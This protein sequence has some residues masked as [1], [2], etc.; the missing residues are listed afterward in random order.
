M[1]KKVYM[2]P[3]MEIVSVQA[4]SMCIESIGKNSSGKV[5][6]STPGLIMA[7]NE[8]EEGFEAD[9]AEDLW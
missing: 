2:T 6:N 7:I 8:R 3:A 1:N 9:A 5:N 4:E